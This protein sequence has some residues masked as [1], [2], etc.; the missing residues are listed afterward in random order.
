MIKIAIIKHRLRILYHLSKPFFVIK[1]EIDQSMSKSQRMIYDNGQL[2]F[3]QDQLTTGKTGNFLSPLKPC[4]GYQ[5]S[6]LSSISTVLS[7][8]G[9]FKEVLTASSLKF[10]CFQQLLRKIKTETTKRAFF[11]GLE[12]SFQ[13]PAT[14]KSPICQRTIML[15]KQRSF[16]KRHPEQPFQRHYN[17]KEYMNEQKQKICHLAGDLPAVE[18]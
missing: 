9:Q 8:Q 3:S 7:G 14:T 1:H 2:L 5:K 6:L 10:I 4:S 13:L 17:A 12:S 16:A 18:S 11:R 15:L